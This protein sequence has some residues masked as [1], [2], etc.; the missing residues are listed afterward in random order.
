MVTCSYSFKQQTNG[1]QSS[2][3]KCIFVQYTRS[4]CASSIEQQSLIKPCMP[5]VT[6]QET[7]HPLVNWQPAGCITFDYNQQINC[8]FA[9]LFYEAFLIYK[10][11]VSTDENDP[12]LK[13][14]CQ[15]LIT[16]LISI[17]YPCRQKN[18]REFHVITRANHGCTGGC[19]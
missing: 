3:I 9:L 15:G 18:T 6:N 4:H 13:L 14:I 19:L 16:G 17:T 11:V 2:N 7:P 10:M 5:V 12:N 1:K 8:L